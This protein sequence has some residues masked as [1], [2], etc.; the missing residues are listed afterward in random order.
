MMRALWTAAS[1][2]ISQQTNVDT[3]ANNIANVNTNGYKTQRAE[4]KSLLYQTIQTETTS[5][6]GETKPTSA[7]VGLGS[8]TASINAMFTQGAMIAS[9]SATAFGISGNGFFQV[10]GY[11]GE[12]YY[13][14]DGNFTWSVGT[15]GMVLTTADGYPVLDVDGDAITIPDGIS[16]ESVSFGQDGTISYTNAAGNTVTTSFGIYQFNNPTGLEKTQD[17][18]YQATDASGA[19]MNEA[20]TDGLTAS[21]IYVGYLE[22]SNV[23]VADEMVDLI[24]AQRAYE[25]NSKAIQT[26]DDMMSTANELKR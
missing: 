26:A 6:N 22:G 4:F 21:K 5:Q 18:L 17:N 19:A 10:R 24:V 8:R 14:R 3:I 20:T 15:D 12:T 11:D 9:E 1:G 25:L 16:T 23:Q 7:Q 13:T 2:M